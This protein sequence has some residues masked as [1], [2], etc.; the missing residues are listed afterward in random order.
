MPWVYDPQSGGVKITPSKQNMF[1]QKADTFART[2]PWFGTYQ[3]KVQFK[4]QFCYVKAVRQGEK[5]P[6]SLCRLRYFRDNIW[7]MAIYT[8]SNSSYQPCYF[9]NGTWEGS[10]EEA[11][12]MCEGYLT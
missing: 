5:K 7:S 10:L 4:E 11:I 2:R 12:E 9:S 8:Y 1:L 3:L 6:F